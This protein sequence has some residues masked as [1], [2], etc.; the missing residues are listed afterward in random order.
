MSEKE[1]QNESQSLVSPKVARWMRY[2]FAS[3]GVLASFFGILI[4][5]GSYLIISPQ[6]DVARGLM[7]SQIDNAVNGVNN[8]DSTLAGAQESLGKVPAMSQNLSSGFQGYAASTLSLADGIDLIAD[9]MGAIYGQ[10]KVTSLKSAATNLRSSAY[11]L[12][13]QSD[14]I[15]GVSSSLDDSIK[16]LGEARKDMQKAQSDLKKAKNEINTMFDSLGYALILACI[17]FSLVFIALGSYSVALF[18]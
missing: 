1:N 14:A 10:D 12:E 8:L 9:E 17:M 4:V 6:I 18:L 5:I 16:G 2:F 13:G 15:V 7:L 11:T 3:I